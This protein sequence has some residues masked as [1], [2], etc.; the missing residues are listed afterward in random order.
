MSIEFTGER[1]VPG[2]VDIDLWN[3]HFARYAFAARYCDGAQVL[4][5]GCGTG[6]GSRA[7]AASALRVTGI[8]QAYDALAYARRE[9]GS[10]SLRW[11]CASCTQIPFH[12]RTFDTVLAFE[13]IEHLQDW[14]RLLSEARRVLRDSGVFIVSTPNKSVYA[15]SRERSG[16]NPYHEHEFEL[17]EFKAALG[18]VF[19]YVTIVLQNHG[20]CISFESSA[21]GEEVRIEGNS[22]P[23]D[24]SFYIAVCSFVR[25]HVPSFVY[26]PQAANLLRERQLHIRRLEHELST[27]NEWLD[28]ARQEH[29]DLVRLHS[30]QT[31][32]LRASNEWAQDLNRKL[33]ENGARILQLQSEL[34]TQ[35]REGLQVASAYQAHVDE[36]E[37]ELQARTAWAQDLERR[38]GELT[39]LLDKAEALVVERT[40]WALSLQND[41]ERAQTKVALARSSRW[42]KLGRA[43]N[44]GPELDG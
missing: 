26:V 28:K 37:K 7:I 43:L 8:D 33:T 19:P 23:A 41:L 17:E 31:D 21:D 27:K 18:A 36:L 3:E 30:D 4:D 25:V 12:D 29:A 6:Y 35:H 40:N 32:E 16:P 39:G 9:Y 5:A 24:A 13:V 2:H 38:S 14:P 44:L 15:E 20:E 11:I 10:D 42:I 1:V 34:E 22:Q